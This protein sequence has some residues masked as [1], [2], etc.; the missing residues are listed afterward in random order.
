MENT[1][2]F[3][4]KHLLQEKEEFTL[5]DMESMPVLLLNQSM[6]GNEKNKDTCTFTSG[7]TTPNRHS[8][9]STLT[10]PR[11]VP[12]NFQQLEMESSTWWHFHASITMLRQPHTWKLPRMYTTKKHYPTISKWTLTWMLTWTLT[13]W[14]TN[15]DI[16]RKKPTFF[17]NHQNSNH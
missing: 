7:S 10:H 9:L 4:G 2:S 16:Q 13:I 17:Q 11:R 5:P 6:P 14:H 8:M 12:Q 15:T 3:P 1:P